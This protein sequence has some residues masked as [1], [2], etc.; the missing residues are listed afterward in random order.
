MLH[1]NQHPKLSRQFFKANPYFTD[2][3]LKK[4]YKYVPPPAAS[5]ETPDAD[6]I[7]DSMLEFSWARDV[8]PSVSCVRPHGIILLTKLVVGNSYS[9][10]G[11]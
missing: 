9:L 5:D 1:D 4:E 6:G 7:T 2:S 3:V 8:Q 11:S 10:E